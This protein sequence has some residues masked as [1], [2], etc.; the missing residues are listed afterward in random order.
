MRLETDF[1]AAKG[2]RIYYIQSAYSLDTPE[3]Q[4]QETR[5]LKNIDDSFKKIVV[6][7]ESGPVRRDENGIMYIGLEEFLLD[8]KSLDL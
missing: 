3:K 2:S 1:I 5:S 7:R 4:D 8:E 6:V